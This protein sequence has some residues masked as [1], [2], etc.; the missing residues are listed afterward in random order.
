MLG[1]QARMDHVGKGDKQCSSEHEVRHDAQEGDWYGCRKD[2][3]RQRDPLDAAQVGGDIRLRSGVDRLE[4][5][6]TKDAVVNN[7]LVDEPGETWRAV[8]L[9]FPL[10][11]AGRAEEHKVLESQHGFRLTVALLLF[12]EGLQSDLR[13]GVCQ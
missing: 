5:P 12:A 7:R 2:Q 10:G 13:S 9:A 8:D 1:L 4:K 6:L 11:C 3:C